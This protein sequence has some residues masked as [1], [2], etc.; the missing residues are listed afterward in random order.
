MI[1]MDVYGEGPPLVLVHGV[2]TSRSIWRHVV[3]ID[4][5]EPAEGPVSGTPVLQLFVID[6]AVIDVDW[7]V[8]G[9]VVA[10][11][12]GTGFD[13]AQ[14][15]LSSGEHVISAKA[16]DNAGEDLVKYRDAVCPD[17]VESWYCHSTGW[18]NATQTVEWTVTVP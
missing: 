9:V 13:L 10:A 3:P 5:T 15:G 14:A 2:A 16:Y 6:P 8:D 7:S 17:S 12:G 4:K 11:K 18:A 1:A